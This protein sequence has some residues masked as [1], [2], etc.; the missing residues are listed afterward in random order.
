VAVL[1]LLFVA[2][3]AVTPG[4]PVVVQGHPTPLRTVRPGVENRWRDLVPAV[5]VLRANP[6]QDE[7]ELVYSDAR[8]A[9]DFLAIN[10]LPDGVR[11]SD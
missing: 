9:L 3:P 2:Q 10:F 11:R 8:S 6:L 1:A 5:E 4:G 7:M